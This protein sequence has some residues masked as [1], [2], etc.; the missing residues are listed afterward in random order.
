MVSE[1]GKNLLTVFLSL[2]LV[3]LMV[4]ILLRIGPSYP[5]LLQYDPVLGV[6]FLPGAEGYFSKEGS[7]YV[8]INRQGF[9][10]PEFPQEKGP[11]EVRI[12]ILGDSFVAALQVEED[13]NFT[14]LLENELKRCQPAVRV[15]NLGVPGYGTVQEYLLSQQIRDLKFDWLILSFYPGNDLINNSPLLSGAEIRPHFDP[16]KNEFDFSFQGREDF[17][18]FSS[19][20]YLRL[21]RI[22]RYSYIARHTLRAIYRMISAEAS[23]P[24][25][26][27]G[28]SCAKETG[29]QRT[30]LREN[31]AGTYQEPRT[32]E[33]RQAWQATETLLFRLHTESRER[34]MQFALLSLSAPVQVFPH[35]ELRS[36][37]ARNLNEPD[38]HYP[39]RR[40]AE[41]SRR[42][43]I[44]FLD[45]L[46][47]MERAL[48]Q[49]SA[50]YFHG[51]GERL[52]TGHYNEEGHRLVAS[53]LA[54]FLRPAIC[55]ER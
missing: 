48:E 3:I 26:D 46:P 9:R 53:E 4:E 19:R 55:K 40:L 47:G 33:W 41:F 25:E 8:K 16:V 30:L 42:R 23:P 29:I 43:G 17:R 20:L 34:G 22:A 36:C 13:Q 24:Q 54:L 44:P 28:A 31:R 38:L 10:N 14:R 35:R 7:S 12:G 39:N 37:L 18:V 5:A 51:F 52:G 32:E 6:R 1:S 50:I 27:T 15:V 2:F 11:G 49:N 21:A 45:V